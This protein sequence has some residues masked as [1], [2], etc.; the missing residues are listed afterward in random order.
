MALLDY[1]H[2]WLSAHPNRTEEWLKER[3][4]DGF[5]VHHADGDPNNNDSSN[6]ILIEGADHMR[7]HGR[8]GLLLGLLSDARQRKKRQRAII[9]RKCYEMRRDQ[10]VTWADIASAM[11]VKCAKS[12]ALAHA[13]ESGDCW[14]LPQN[15]AM[16]KARGWRRAR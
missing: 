2:A 5:H 4:E 15:P 16:H 10:D 3:L 1:H 7:L 13:E 11:G 14:P 6:L 8:E 9:N 12:R